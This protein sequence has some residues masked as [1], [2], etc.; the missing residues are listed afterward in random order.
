MKCLFKLP[1]F[2]CLLCSVTMFSQTDIAGFVDLSKKDYASFNFLGVNSPYV[3]YRII[4]NNDSIPG[5]MMDDFNQLGDI[6]F[7][8]PGGEISN[9]YHLYDSTGTPVTGYGISRWEINQV[10]NKIQCDN[11]NGYYCKGNDKD[12]PRNFL[13]DLKDMGKW[14]YQRAG[15]PMKI[16]YLTNI[17]GHFIHDKAQIDQLENIQNLASIDELVSNGIISQSFAIRIKENLEM[18]N[19]IENDPYLQIAGIEFGNEFYFHEKITELSYVQINALSENEFQAQKPTLKSNLNNNISKY[20]KLIITYK[21]LFSAIKPDF[22]Y[23]VPT[24]FLLISGETQHVAELWN[25]A[26]KE[27]DVIGLVNGLSHHWYAKL[28]GPA[29]L[30]P[31]QSEFPNNADEMDELN[32]SV[33]NFF[34]ANLNQNINTYYNYY[35]FANNGKKLWITEFEADNADGIMV[36]WYNTM[37]HG[38]FL[39]RWLTGIA[40]NPIVKHCYHQGLATSQNEYDYTLYSVLPGKKEALKR[41]AFYIMQFMGELYGKNIS[42]IENTLTEPYDE[43]LLA[44]KMFFK[45]PENTGSYGTFYYYFSN[46]SGDDLDIDLTYFLFQ[47]INANALKIYSAKYITA[48]HL[49]SSCGATQ[50]GYDNEDYDVE[51]KQ[52]TF[53]DKK[54]KIG[55]YSTGF[56]KVEFKNPTAVQLNDISVSAKLFPNPAKEKAW[57]YFDDPALK[58]KQFS[59]SFTNILGEQL[60]TDQMNNGIYTLNLKDLAS[61]VYLIR[62]ESNED[63]AIKKLIIP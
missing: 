26:M 33:Y 5:F 29:I 1:L 7:R 47:N 16:M 45:E 14:H 24:A 32:T 15:K 38:D 61:G 52:D 3:F 37:F 50:F 42:T 46:K 56:I 49:Y 28:L 36:R 10:D 58:S 39:F 17:Y 63:Y 21:K 40:T 4:D 55:K 43:K 2:V 53:P 6:T 25:E 27:N 62:L 35:D 12:A 34:N 23:S 48:P 60:L 59:V 44:T 41:T 57:I 31:L 9:F 18:V 8:Y 13:E 54:F 51:F 20:K 11:N 19:E 30:N 22:E